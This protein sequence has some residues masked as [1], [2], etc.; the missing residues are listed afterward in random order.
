VQGNVISHGII[1]SIFKHINDLC[2][3]SDT[4]CSQDA[5]GIVLKEHQYHE[6]GFHQGLLI[7]EVLQ[8]LDFQGQDA[9]L[10]LRTT[11]DQDKRKQHC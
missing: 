2:S 1:K 7:G 4:K 8:G 6:Q 3:L 5:A 10:S 9:I 11:K